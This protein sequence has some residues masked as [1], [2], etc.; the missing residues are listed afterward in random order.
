MRILLS[1]R[2]PDDLASAL[3]L[4]GLASAFAGL[5]SIVLTSDDAGSVSVVGGFALC[6]LVGEG[7]RAFQ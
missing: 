2:L 3:Y 6:A 5:A 1:L 4:A 7:H